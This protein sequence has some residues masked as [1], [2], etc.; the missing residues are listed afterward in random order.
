[1]EIDWN[2]EACWGLAQTCPAYKRL[3]LYSCVHAQVAMYLKSKGIQKNKFS[4]NKNNMP[5]N[6]AM[7]IFQSKVYADA[8][9]VK[10]LFWEF[11]F[12]INRIFKE[13]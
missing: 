3:G 10:F 4:I 11:R 5:S 8:Y 2:V 6:Q 7:S 9:S 12:I 1:M 13:E